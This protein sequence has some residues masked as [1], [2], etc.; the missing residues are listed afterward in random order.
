MSHVLTRC[1]EKRFIPDSSHRNAAIQNAE[2]H[3]VIRHGRLRSDF[4]EI[5]SQY[6]EQHDQLTYQLQETPLVTQVLDCCACGFEY[7]AN[8]D[9][10][11]ALMH[12]GGYLPAGVTARETYPPSSTRT[13]LHVQ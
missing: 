6:E 10:L 13:R 7:S 4:E 1:Y 8:V 11:R 9:C 12:A 3:E 5:Y 2:E